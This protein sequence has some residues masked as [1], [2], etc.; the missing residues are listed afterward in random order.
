MTF[1]DWY[2]DRFGITVSQAERGARPDLLL[3]K[4]RDCWEEAEKHGASLKSARDIALR[5]V[6]AEAC[7]YAH[8]LALML[9]KQHY[10]DVAGWMPLPDLIGL[11]T[12]IDNMTAGLTKVER[13]CKHVFEDD[14]CVVCGGVA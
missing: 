1:D 12:Q 7:A 4:Y 13:K 3:R 6:Q 10:S 2:F 8:N 9:W 5:K 14:R 11:L